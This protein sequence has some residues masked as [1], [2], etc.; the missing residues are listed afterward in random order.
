MLSAADA[1]LAE[2]R[3]CV[4]DCTIVVCGGCIA[5]MVDGA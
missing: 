3:L 2:A 5:R 4:G 1:V